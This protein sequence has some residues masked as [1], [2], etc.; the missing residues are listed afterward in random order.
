[1]F[2][3]NDLEK[4]AYAIQNTIGNQDRSLVY[5]RLLK[6]FIQYQFYAFDKS[7]DQLLVENGFSQ[8]KFWPPS[9]SKSR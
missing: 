1:M 3:L 9:I 8:T 2:L 6:L 5:H 4:M 7:W